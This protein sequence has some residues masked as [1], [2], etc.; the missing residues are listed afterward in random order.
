MM[1]DC[2]LVI[3]MGIMSPMSCSP[4]GF[5]FC[6][7]RQ[8]FRKWVVYLFFRG[9]SQQGWSPCLLWWVLSLPLSLNANPVIT[10]P[11]IN[12]AKEVEGKDALGEGQCGKAQSQDGAGCIL[13]IA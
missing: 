6:V 11:L 9:S 10:V 1:H 8:E 13:G 3:R 7:C 12:S 4:P 5:S 2:C